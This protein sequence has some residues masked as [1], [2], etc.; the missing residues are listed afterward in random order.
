MRPHLLQQP[1]AISSL[2][3]LL[4]FNIAEYFVLVDGA[5]ELAKDLEA[6]I[7]PVWFEIV[8]IVVVCLRVWD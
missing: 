6:L 2:D 1:G 8:V 7:I 5:V 4:P 3:S